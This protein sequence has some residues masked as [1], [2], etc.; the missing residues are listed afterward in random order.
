MKKEKKISPFMKFDEVGWKDADI[1]REIS[2][3]KK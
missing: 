3:A 2:F 1:K